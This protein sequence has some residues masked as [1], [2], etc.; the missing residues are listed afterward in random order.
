M[1]ID[2]STHNHPAT[3]AARAT[4]RKEMTFGPVAQL[5]SNVVSTRGGKVH[6]GTA[7]TFPVCRSGGQDSGRTRYMETDAPATCLACGPE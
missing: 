4:C 3:P 2:H 5:P 7:D 1:R 6:K